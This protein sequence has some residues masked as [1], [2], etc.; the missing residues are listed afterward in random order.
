MRDCCTQ[1]NPCGLGQGDCD[2]TDDCSGDLLCG[3][4]NCGSKFYT[5][6]DCC[7]TKEGIV[8]KILWPTHDHTHYYHDT[9]TNS[10]HQITDIDGPCNGGSESDMETCCDKRGPCGIGQGHCTSDFHCSRGLICGNNNCG[11]KFTWCNADCCQ[12]NDSRLSQCFSW[13]LFLFSSIC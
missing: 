13:V 10:M 5:D 7:A 6:A 8:I 4:D 11:P 9:S 2:G 3:K 1:R 12:E